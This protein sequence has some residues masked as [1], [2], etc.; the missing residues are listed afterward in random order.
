PSASAPLVQGIQGTYTWRPVDGPGE[1]G[2]FGALAGGDAGGKASVPE[3]ET[4]FSYH[5]PESAYDATTRTETTVGGNGGRAALAT[6]TVGQWPPVWRVATHSPL[7]YQGLAAIVRTAVED[8]DEAVGIKPVKDDERAVW[9][10]AMKL[11]GKEVN[12]V[13]DQQTGIVT[14]CSDDEAT[15]TATVD[16]DAPPPADTTYSVDVPAGTETETIGDTDA[17]EPSPAAAGRTAGYAP[18][19]SDLAPDGYGLQSVAT[20][21]DGTQV[22]DWTGHPTEAGPISPP[23]ELVIGQLYTRGLSWFTLEQLGPKATDFYGAGLKDWPASSSDERLSLQQ[24]TLQY[25]RLKGATAYTW[26]QES[27]PSLFAAGR[28]RA[29]FITGA[30]TRQELIAFAEGLQPVAPPQ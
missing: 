19:V 2:T 28:R 9:R 15:F 6:R 16:W 3:D 22:Y 26:Y 25:G 1:D 13:V 30:L 4:V 8:G 20:V 5:P 7:D 18:L 21:A 10:A 14:W 12:V 17:Y 27:G 23:R 24:T 11:D 29:V